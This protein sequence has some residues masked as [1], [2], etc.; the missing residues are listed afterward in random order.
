VPSQLRAPSGKPAKE[1]TL[2]EVDMKLDEARM[3]MMSGGRWEFVEE[4][5]NDWLDARAKL[6]RARKP[7]LVTK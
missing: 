6:G 3:Y 4:F 5:V 2:R 1:A 7:K